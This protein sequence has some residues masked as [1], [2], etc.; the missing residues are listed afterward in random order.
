MK[1]RNNLFHSL[2]YL[3]LT[4]VFVAGII[5]IIAS[6]GGGDGEPNPY[7]ALF[8]GEYQLQTVEF[9]WD[10]M[11]IVSA[12]IVADGLGNFTYGTGTIA[13]NIT[14]ERLFSLSDPNDATIEPEYGIIASDGSLLV[15]T[16][17]QYVDPYSQYDVET[18]I[19]VK[20]SSSTPMTL[21]RASGEYIVN[22]IGQNTQGYYTSRIEVVLQNGSGNWEILNHTQTA[23]VGLTGSFSYSVSADGTISVNTGD[24]GIVAPDANM[25]VMTDTDF[26]DGEIHFAVGI[27]KSAS[28]PVFSTENYQL[29]FI[30]Y[31]SSK[32]PPDGPQF[33]ARWDVVE[34][35][36]N[37]E[38]D[39]T[40]IIDSR[41]TPTGTVV[42]IPHTAVATDGTF[43]AA[44]TDYGIV[45]PD[46]AYFS[47][48]ETD[49]DAVSDS[50]IKLGFAI[51]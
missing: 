24:T 12:D 43:D 22:Q 46:G 11:N 18:H 20:K 21:A 42:S 44:L 4:G 48:V 25:F 19:V 32:I 2:R 5:T 40:A 49:T 39:A 35:T 27:R 16:D 17:A 13:Y 26:N 47:V 41:G 1:I 3:S 34:D 6:G 10:H 8:S 45:A 38:F 50:E 37:L 15:I 28:A 29:H 30:G 31:D 36:A 7:N 33:A 23:E 51:H 9:E 14:A